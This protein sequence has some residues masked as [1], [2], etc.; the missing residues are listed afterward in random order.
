MKQNSSKV[1]NV[2]IEVETTNTKSIKLV[3]KKLN[4]IGVELDTT[5]MP[6]V[7]KVTQTDAQ[8]LFLLKGRIIQSLIK[9][10]ENC[11]NVINY[12]ELKTNIPFKQDV[13]LL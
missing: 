12:W 6:K 2:F 1:K 11:P 3:T 4:S 8:K 5:F 10:L 9:E 7:L 13:T